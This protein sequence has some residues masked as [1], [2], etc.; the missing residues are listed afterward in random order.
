M[1]FY[2]S[3]YAGT[4]RGRQRKS[5]VNS[6]RAFSV[7]SIEQSDEIGLATFAAT[8]AKPVVPSFA[9]KRLTAGHAGTFGRYVVDGAVIHHQFFGFQRTVR[10]A[11]LRVPS[12]RR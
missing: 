8:Q 12:F 11:H 1:A 10:F 3:R 4:I 6:R 2:H 9:G 7:I 5:P